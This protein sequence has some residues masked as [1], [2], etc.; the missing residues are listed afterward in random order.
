MG[1]RVGHPASRTPWTEPEA[2]P[3]LGASQAK[4]EDVILNYP[5]KRG[6]RHLSTQH[7]Y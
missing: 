4:A 3:A 6:Q 1:D 7:P 2:T 5:V